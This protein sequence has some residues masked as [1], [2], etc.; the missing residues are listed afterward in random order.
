[1]W[2]KYCCETKT[3]GTS[4]IP[5]DGCDGGELSM[6]SICCEQNNHQE[7]LHNEGCVDSEG[8]GNSN[9]FLIYRNEYMF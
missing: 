3:E 6:S 5:I 8:D 2:G 9:T 1:M 7:C 4:S